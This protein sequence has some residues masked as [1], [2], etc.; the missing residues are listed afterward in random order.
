MR[1]ILDRHR[2]ERGAPPSVP[3]RF[4]TRAGNVVV[5][6]HDLADYDALRS[7]NRDGNDKDNGN[8]NDHEN[9]HDH[10]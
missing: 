5:R 4:T 3:H 7:D 9:E 1:Q 8:D 6:P 2:A 10:Q